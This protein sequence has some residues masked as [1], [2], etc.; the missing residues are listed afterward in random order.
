M[1]HEQLGERARAVLDGIYR[2]EI[3]AWR[4]LFE[5]RVNQGR[6]TTDIS[7]A[8]RAATFR[9]VQTL[10]DID[11]AILGLLDESG[12]VTFAEQAV[13]SNY[14]VIDEIAARVIATGGRVI[15]V[16]KT[17]IPRKEALAAILRYDA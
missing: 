16:R 8:A 14:D 17:D 5:E 13:P 9:A 12:A 2:E 10:V 1:P 7:Q 4:S 11:E 3:V 15:G 6:A